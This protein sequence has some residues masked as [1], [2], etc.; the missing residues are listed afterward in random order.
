MSGLGGL[1]A[2]ATH[3]AVTL[4]II[5]AFRVTFNYAKYFRFQFKRNES[6]GRHDLKLIRGGCDLS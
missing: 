2:W 3:Y 4:I 5:L 1:G 6:E